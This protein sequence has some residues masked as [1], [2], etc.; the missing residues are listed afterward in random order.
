MIGVRPYDYRRKMDCVFKGRRYTVRDNGAVYRHAKE[1]RQPLEAD[2]HWTFG[3]PNNKT[4]YMELASVRVHRIVATAYHGEAPSPEHVV[5]HIDTN[6]RNNRPENLRWVTKMENLLNNPITVARIKYRFGTVEHFLELSP[7][8]RNQEKKPDYS[9]MRPVNPQE[10][11]LSL[12]RLN[13][14][15]T[16][17]KP[18]KGGALGPWIY[19]PTQNETSTDQPLEDTL[20]ITVNAVQRQWRV[21]C[22]FPCCPEA[23]GELPISSY[24]KNLAQEKVFCQNEFKKSIVEDY[25][26]STDCRKLWVLCHFDRESTKP[27]SLAEVTFENGVFVHKNLGS[28]FGLDGAQKTLCL[29]QGNAWEGGTTFDELC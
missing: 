19:Q 18:T 7:E 29:A 20:A 22:E 17:N 14:Y 4:G 13:E 6:R 21:P 15:V 16:E 12:Q 24:A 9:W 11:Q 28:Y 2:E 8:E 1:G 27:W 10:A 25:D 3:R 5:D 26:L 23:V